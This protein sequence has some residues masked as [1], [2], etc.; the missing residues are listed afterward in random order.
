MMP[1]HHVSAVRS[2]VPASQVFRPA[3]PLTPEGLVFAFAGLVLGVLAFHLGAGT[4]KGAL[5]LGKLAF[6]GKAAKFE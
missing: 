3:V 6:R 4:C 1:R 2:T 5:G